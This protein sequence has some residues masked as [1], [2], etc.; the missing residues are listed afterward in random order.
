MPAR[1]AR[2][3]G[4]GRADAA[5][6][7][8]RCSPRSA[9]RRSTSADWMW[10]P[11]L[12]G[13]RVLAFIDAGRRAAALAA[14]P[15]ARRRTFRSSSPSS[16]KQAVDGMILD[17]EIVAF[18]ADGRPSFNALQNRAQ[19]KT[20]REIAAADQRR[21]SCSTAS[22][23]CISRAS[24]CAARRT[25][26]RRR[27]LTQCLLP[28]PLVQ[29]VHASD[30]GVALARGRAR[31]RLRR[32]GRQAQ[33]QPLRARQALGVLAQG[34]ADAERGVRGRRLHAGQGRARAARR[35]ARRLL[36]RAASCATRRT[37]APASTTA[38]S[39]TCRARLE[40]LQRETCP[41]AEKPELQRAD[42]LGRAE[43][44]RRSE[45]PELD[46]RRPSARAGVPAP[47]RRHR[48][49]RSVRR[50]KPGDAGGD[51]SCA[52]AATIDDVVAQLDDARRRRS[53]S[54]SAR[55]RSGSRTSIACTGRRTRR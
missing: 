4:R 20:E 47:A 43:A 35:A 50:A 44:R 42:D 46:R 54:R 45:I 2:A 11:K 51:A 16:R 14:R 49:R 29:L 52:P 48:P 18:D 15:R 36:G 33:G 34:Q 8:R 10:E 7:S 19:L 40:P 26:D 21:R 55:T 38:R 22:T 25:R 41:F 28:S 53:R 3:R 31:E 1:A 6:S 23:C 13:Y 9:T 39:P 30:D 5:R 17:G 12:D 37:S 24:T 27:Y 32:R